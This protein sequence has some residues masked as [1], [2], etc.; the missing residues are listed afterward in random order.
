MDLGGEGEDLA[1]NFL[2]PPRV[3]R[4]SELLRSLGLGRELPKV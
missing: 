3:G 4:K 1:H 2:D